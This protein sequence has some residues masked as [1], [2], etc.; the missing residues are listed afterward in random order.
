VSS[1]FGPAH[2]AAFV[3]VVLVLLALDL[4]LGRRADGLVSPRR[5]LLASAGFVAAALGF[6]AFLR[7]RLGAG[8]ALDF[9]AGF[10]VEKALSVD[11]VFVILVTL[12]AFR[13]PEASWRRVLTLGIL[14][15]LVM[16][17]ALIV[18]GTSLLHHVHAATYLLGALLVVT[19][20]K[21]LFAKKDEPAPDAPPPLVVR[22]CR[23][24]F[25]VT[26]EHRGGR[27]FV[28][29][30]GRLHLTPLFL[31]LVAVEVGDVVFA[32]DSIPAVMAITTD[33]FLVFTSN[34]FAILGLRSLF[35]ALRGLVARF[36]YLE[37]GVS[38]VLLFVG[39]KML[40][41]SFVSISTPASLAVIGLLLAGAVVASARREQALAREGAAS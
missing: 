4:G 5:A 40:L 12:T 37:A 35:F 20:L 29:E 10:V 36:H 19:A 14:G 7:V 24:F 23:R 3:A 8:P 28:R 26:A 39:G 34:V 30:A 2:W 11:N 18:A 41:A 16:R 25:P 32:A 31:A 6:A 13:V 38:L 33:P 15:A 9:L 1:P 22:L 27:F 17:G 21:L